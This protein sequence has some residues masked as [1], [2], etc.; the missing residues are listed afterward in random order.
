MRTRVLWLALLLVVAA[1]GRAAAGD[2]PPVKLGLVV[3]MAGEAG[4]VGQTMRRAAEMAVADWAPRLERP[5]ALTVKDDGFDPRQAVAVAEKLVR[6]GIWGVVGHFYSSSSIPASAV[7]FAAG[8]PQITPTSTH[9]RLTA[10]G[11]DTVFRVSGR[12][13][14]HAL[15]AAAFALGRLRARR[16]AVVHDRTEYG[17]TLAET[18]VRAVERAGRRPLTVEEIVQGDRDFGAVVTRLKGLAPDLIYF[19][20][21][22]REG[23]HLLR[24]LREA[25]VEAAFMSADGVLD[26]EF[27]KLAGEQAAS[28]A[29]L[30]FAPDPRLLPSARPLI[31]RF[32]ERH[33]PIGPYVLYTYDAVGALLN[34]VRL[35]RPAGNTADDLRRVAKVLRASPYDGALGRLRWDARGDLVASPYVIYVTR[36]GGSLHGWF[37]QL[38]D[39]AVSRAGVQAVRGGRHP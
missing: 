39:S 28:G 30:T 10:Q 35:A 26:P 27:V 7:Y 20:G 9:P 1:G 13:D 15:S 22:F 8:I 3:P 34:A 14:H 32:E 6:E 21:I 12:D 2:L 38:P 33:G 5:V 25:G 18:L 29:Y 19:G 23:G 24:Q 17:R 11:F 31:R 16:I 4:R 36:K 37:E